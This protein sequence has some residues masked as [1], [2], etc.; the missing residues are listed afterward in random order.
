MIN[1]TYNVLKN[2]FVLDSHCDTPSQIFRLRD[3]GL[4]N[5]HAHVDLPKMKAGGVDG[6]FFALFVPSY[7]APD[8]ATRYALELLALVHDSIDANPDKARMAVSV[9]EALEIQ[10]QGLVSIFIGME[11]G[12]PIQK[13]LPLLRLFHRMGVRYITLCHNGDNALCDAASQGTTWH[14]LSP[15]G[16]EAVHE[17][18]R[19]G[20]MV[21]IAHASDETFWDCIEC[22]KAPI[23]STHS[24][25]RALA[26]H[27]RN[28]TD[29]MIKAL[30][31]KGGVIQINF[32][33]LF[34]SDE[35][36]EVLDKSG[37]DP[38]AEEIETAFRADP[39]DPAK[40]A[41]WYAVQDELLTLPRPGVATIVDHI[42]HAVKVGG[43]DHVGIGS[44]FDGI[45]VAPDG[46][47]NISMIGKIFD[48]MRR[49][50][51]GEDEIAKVAGGNFLRVL[52][53]VANI[54]VS[55]R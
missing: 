10:S 24:C 54:A 13:S 44:D 12:S 3:I 49:R 35:F 51:Y 53:E 17:M 25:C 27:R 11:N 30:A 29:D 38:R 46:L 45:N 31:D 52:D 16:R 20:M 28:L 6:S 39:A 21:D 22:S 18:N 55:M 41:A 42:D 34:L 5:A 8:T 48:E 4:D 37:M 33:P 9:Q 43:I 32:Y 23:V 14:G 50:G 40:R 26:G 19:I 15:F 1:K 7:M 2:M 47:E 36:A